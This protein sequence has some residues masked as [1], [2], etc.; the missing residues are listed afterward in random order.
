[1]F[2]GLK[3][4]VKKLFRKKHADAPHE[5]HPEASV[6][7]DTSAGDLPVL[8]EKEDLSALFGVEK[9]ASDPAAD[10]ADTASTPPRPVLKNK[11]NR[12]KN[13]SV[14]RFNKHGVPV[15]DS[16]VEVSE[17]F[18][19]AGQN[20]SDF[21]IKNNR[22]SEVSHPSGRRPKPS[23]AT[24]PEKTPAGRQ[25]TRLNKHGLPILHQGS[26][27]GRLFT[28]KTDRKIHSPASNGETFIPPET[29]EQENFSEL[30]EQS[31]TGK[32]QRAL[33]KAKKDN[34]YPRKPLTIKQRIK[35]YPAPQ[36]QL[37]LHGFTA[38]EAQQRVE[39][40][41]RNA[42][43]RQI[44][45]LRLIVGKGLHSEFGPVLPDVVEDKLI[46]L[47]R[48]NIVLAYEWD[49]KKKS[50]SGAVIVYLAIYGDS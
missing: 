38:R 25:K 35:R 28:T 46:E 15:F 32:N 12:K 2:S 21:K 7:T 5:S 27:L 31:L 9:S 37:D 39:A 18:E 20:T 19:E 14:K 33:L 40:Y 22:V 36:G 49:K 23:P 10:M 29:P 45:T 30:L 48:Q 42:H 44:F 50:K 24:S 41:L 1:M 4:I 17:L 8:S 43:H 6:Q 16:K 3:N 11:K 47:K 13:R 26:D 34:L